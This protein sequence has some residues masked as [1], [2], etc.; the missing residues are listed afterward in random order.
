MRA[1]HMTIR[2]SVASAADRKLFDSLLVLQAVWDRID[3][4]YVW[5]DRTIRAPQAGSPDFN[6]KIISARFDETRTLSAVGTSVVL[7]FPRLQSLE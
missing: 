4:K 3:E 6:S 5:A 2:F 7:I 1:P